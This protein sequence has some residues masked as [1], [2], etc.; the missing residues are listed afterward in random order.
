MTCTGR[1][2]RTSRVKPFTGRICSTVLDKHDGLGYDVVVKLMQ[3]YFNQGYHLYIDNFYT[4][5]VLVK[6]LFQQG[7]P[8]TGTIRENSRGFPQNLKNGAQWSKA[9]NVQ[10]GSMRWER[11]PPLLALQWLDNKVVSLF[12]YFF[13]CILIIFIDYQF[14][15]Q[16]TTLTYYLLHSLTHTYIQAHTHPNDK[17]TKILKL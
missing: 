8:T 5:S 9:S 7:V 4:S 13:F 10:R 16:F 1:T 6:Y 12:F 15:I 11:D 17:S 2:G 14:Y 3:P